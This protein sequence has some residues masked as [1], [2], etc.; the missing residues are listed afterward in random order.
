MKKINLKIIAISFMVI[1]TGCTS[2]YYQPID[3]PDDSVINSDNTDDTTGN[4]NSTDPNAG[5][6]T[7]YGDVKPILSQL[8]VSCHGPVDPKDD[9]D[10]STYEKAKN[11]IDEIIEEIQ[12]D[13]D[14][15]MPPSG[16]M[17]E[18]LIQLIKDWKSDGLLEGDSNA[19]DNTGNTSGN[20]TY[21]VDIKPILDQECT[22]CHGATNP[23]AGL[24]ISTY[25]K[26]T[27][28]IDKIIT[29]I[30]LQTGQNGIM[31]PNGRMAEI[32]IQ[33]IKDW[34]ASGMKEQ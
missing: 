31:P 19:G 34:K 2:D 7:Y 8:C 27:N 33:K 21:V 28:N 4:D 15:I 29:S 6:V 3:P 9:F 22:A 23:A 25:T 14:D 24:D 30:D 10:I 18:N 12:E 20:Y 26:T 5:K 13:G 17:A 1:F 16:R 11:E 32:K